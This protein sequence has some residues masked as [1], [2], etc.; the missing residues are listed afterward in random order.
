[1]FPQD[2]RICKEPLATVSRVPVCLRCLE[3]PKPFAAE[4]F[5]AECRT[6]FLNASPLDEHGRCGLCRRGLSGFDAAYSFGAYEGALR[7]LI[8]LLKYSRIAP[9]AAPLGRM[10]GSAFPRDERFDAIVPMPLHWLRR[11]RRGFNQAELLSRALARQTGLPIRRLVRRRRSTAAQAG[12]TNAGRRANVTG[13]FTVPRDDSVKGLR[14]LLIDDVFTTGASAGACARALKRAG[15]ARVAVLTLAR[16]DR[17]F[18]PA[19]A[20]DFSPLRS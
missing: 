13:A 20:A 16:A 8:H 3:Q 6:P 19:A 12:L 2:C 5:C 10:M 9:L 7:E 1:M 11:W 18:A 4:Y 17:R 14:L 15:A